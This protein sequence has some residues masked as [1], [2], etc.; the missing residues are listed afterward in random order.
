V[1]GG[2]KLVL[3]KR[4]WGIVLNELRVEKGLSKT[5]LA[6]RCTRMSSPHVKINRVYISQLEHGYVKTPLSA[7]LRAA[8]LAGLE[9]T[10]EHFESHRVQVYSPCKVP[11]FE[12][13]PVPAGKPSPCSYITV[14]LP[15]V[16][17]S[18][19]QSLNA[20]CFPGSSAESDIAKG[21]ILVIDAAA[22]LS[23]GNTVVCCAADGLHT[24]KIARVD[25]SLYV[26]NN[27]GCFAVDGKFP[28]ARVLQ[29]VR[30]L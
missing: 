17:G 1:I 18:G 21:D 30:N 29:V 16:W 6:A 5:D 13:F 12:S 3:K 25:G 11:V 19:N 14:A 27:L 22:V 4:R 24:G 23:V 9:I 2:G 10:E 28:V 20:F 15:A 8:L 7:K 26:K